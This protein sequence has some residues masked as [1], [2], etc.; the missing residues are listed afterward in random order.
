MRANLVYWYSG[1]LVFGLASVL[2]YYIALDVESLFFNAVSLFCLLG[3]ICFSMQQMNVV[4]GNFLFVFMF[5]FSAIAVVVVEYGVYLPEIDV[6]TFFQGA[7]ARNILL[8]IFFAAVMQVI[9]LGIF[10]ISTGRVAKVKGLD[11]LLL[12]V[13]PPMCFLLLL[14]YVVVIII[15]GSPLLMGVDRFYFWR[16]IAPPW[17]R[18]VHTLM[19]QLAFIVS[20]AFSVGHLRKRA[21]LLW[22]GVAVLAVIAGG[23]KFSGLFLMLVFAALPVFI[24][25]VRAGKGALKV[26]FGFSVFMCLLMG[27]VAI[28]Y[29]SIYGDAFYDK[30]LT[31]I[32]LQGQMLWALDQRATLEGLSADVVWRSLFGLGA[33]DTN[34]GMPYLMYLV[35]PAATVDAYLAGGATFTAPFPANIQV[36]FGYN[37]APVVV[38]VIACVVGA[39]S[40]LLM[41]SIKSRSLIFSLLLIKFYWFF[42]IAVAMGELRT[43][44]DWKYGLYVFLVLAMLLAS[45]GRKS[46]KGVGHVE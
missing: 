4:V 9:S 43:A 16:S 2:M 6:T 13:M 34:A 8:M 17:F 30:I 18:Y 5:L 45:A 26:I 32:A 20:F 23:E 12:K 29:I 28:S 37:L 27:V 21:A 31:R 19:P 24:L 22:G 11:G 33:E 46:Y 3:F 42:Y 7:A 15:Y 39:L 44:F 35:A 14:F 25:R 36:F 40:G 10:Q 38:A 1:Q 41:A